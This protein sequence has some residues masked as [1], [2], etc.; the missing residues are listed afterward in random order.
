MIRKFLAFLFGKSASKTP[1]YFPPFRYCTGLC[2]KV[3][4]GFYRYC[5]YFGDWNIIWFER[6]WDV[7]SASETAD[8]LSVRYGNGNFKHISSHRVNPDCIGAFKEW[9]ILRCAD[10]RE[11]L[12]ISLA[13]PVRKAAVYGEMFAKADGKLSGRVFELLLAYED[14]NMAYGYRVIAVISRRNP[15]G[16]LAV[17]HDPWTHADIGPVAPQHPHEVS[18]GDPKGKA[19]DNNDGGFH[20]GTLAAAPENGTR[21]ITRKGGVK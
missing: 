8:S 6:G 14:E 10:K 7:V 9:H 21:K 5:D 16:E 12:C 2:I 15:E 3:R 19:G 18:E 4:D 13:E 17:C 1:P 11:T 20:T